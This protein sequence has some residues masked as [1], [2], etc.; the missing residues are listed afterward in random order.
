VHSSTGAG[1]DEHEPRNECERD[2]QRLAIKASEASLGPFVT[3]E[4]LRSPVASDGDPQPSVSDRAGL[5]LGNSFHKSAEPRHAAA[6]VKV[7]PLIVST[8]VSARVP[9]KT[10]VR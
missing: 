4:Y 5:E 10:I 6:A 9:C 2:E 1:S 7:L 8:S 3:L